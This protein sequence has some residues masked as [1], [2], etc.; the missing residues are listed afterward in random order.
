[1]LKFKIV[2]VCID[3]VNVG[4]E[5]TKYAQW[6]HGN[7]LYLILNYIREN[8]SAADE[9]HVMNIQLRFSYRTNMK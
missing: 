7:D 9:S 4:G 2:I 6:K 1:M 8:F 5:Y 3:D